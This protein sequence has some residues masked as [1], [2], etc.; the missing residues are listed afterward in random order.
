MPNYKAIHDF[1]LKSSISTAYQID[2]SIGGCEH[3]VIFVPPQPVRDAMH[4]P[5]RRGMTV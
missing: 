1:I 3:V 2:M 4:H 5:T